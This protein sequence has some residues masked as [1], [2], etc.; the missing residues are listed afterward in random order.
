MTTQIGKLVE[1]DKAHLWHHI[2]QHANFKNNDPLI[3]TEGKGMRVWDI[4]G[5]EYLDALS[6]GVWSV[7]VGYGEKRIVDAVSE[8][9]MKMC[10]FSGTVGTI[11]SVELAE[12]IVKKMDGL[13]RVYLSPSGSEANEKAFKMVRQRAALK[14]D[15][16]K[17]KILYRD[18]DYHGT[19]ITALS[20]G[21]QE[22]RK[23]QYGPYTPGFVEFEHCCCYRCPFD[24]KYGSC[25]IECAK[26]V[27][28]TI[29]REGPENVGGVIIEPITAGGGIIAP[30]KEYMPMVREICDKYDVWLIIDEVVCGL[31]RTGKWF[32]YQHYGIIP[33]IVTTA[34]GLASSYAPLAATITT[35]EVFNEFVNDPSD[36]ASYFRD[37]STYGGCAG[38]AAAGM[39]NIKVI[40][41]D[42]LVENSR[43]VGDYFLEQLKEKLGSHKNVGDIR[44]VGLFAGVELVVDRGTKEAMSEKTLAEIVGHCM[45][46]GVIIGRTNRSLPKLNNTLTFCPALIATKAD[47]DQIV[48]STMEGMAAVLG[49]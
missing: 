43:I 37:I 48:K 20:A 16:Q 11:P 21:G 9:I 26:T 28:E 15:G 13:S 17:Y 25:S 36:L 41:D 8:Q 3:I 7:N 1:K 42:N 6:G 49:E 4:N 34:K 30:V 32:G 35:E 23:M 33:D 38:S 24:K 40:E 10:Y 12:S 44:G 46:N 5:K 2:T 22:E 18:R 45:K 27:E 39:A 31:G 19:T 14:F 29:L 47:I